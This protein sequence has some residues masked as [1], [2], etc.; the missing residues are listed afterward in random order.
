MNNLGVDVLPHIVN[1]LLVTT[2]LLAGNTYVYAT[3]RSLYGLALDGKAP[4]IIHKCTKRGI[5]IYC[6][7]VVMAF[8]FLSFL[9]LSSSSATVLT[10]L[11]QLL[12]GGAVTNFIVMSSTYIFFHRAWKHQGR[13]PSNLPY[14]GWFQP[15][16]GY[17]AFVWMTCIAF[18]HGYSSFKP[19]NVT[20]FFTHYTMILLGIV[21]F[22]SWKLIKRTSIVRPEEADLQWD[23]DRI[24]AY[25]EAASV[26]D[27]PNGFWTETFVFHRWKSR[28]SVTP[29]D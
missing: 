8:A 1:V 2:V 4:R 3:S 25:E 9:Q 23:G 28:Q 15:W 10:L 11:V 19:W 13:D 17:I 5:P 26:N 18:C 7:V 20:E 14:K 12:S 21:T 24:T 22:S 29:V 6:F 16:C 27:P